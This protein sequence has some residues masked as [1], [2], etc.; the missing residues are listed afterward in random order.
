[1]VQTDAR[2]PVPLTRYTLAGDFTR[3]STPIHEHVYQRVPEACLK[4]A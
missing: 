4:R 3:V 2:N 1:M